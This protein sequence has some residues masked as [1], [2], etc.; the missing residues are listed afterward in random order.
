MKQRPPALGF[1][2]LASSFSLLISGPSARASEP[3]HS[4]HRHATT[5]SDEAMRKMADSYW[6]THKRVGTSATIEG[7]PAATF[8]VANFAF[9]NA[10]NGSTTAEIVAGQSVLWQW[11]VG[12]HTVTSG[13]D[14]TDPNA[15]ALFNQPSDTFNRTFTFTFNTPGTYPFF[16]FFHG[17]INGM[18][19][20]VI[21]T[22]P[23]GVEPLPDNGQAT[24]FAAGPLPNPTRA[25]ISFRFSLR[26]PGPA[27]AEVFDTRGRRIAT[28]LD[29]ELPA[30][31]YAGSWDGR[32][33]TG[34]A[35]AGIYYLRL[36][37]PGFAASRRFA[38]TH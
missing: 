13:T 7:A 38:I 26:T 5:M 19:G 29:R 34:V 4:S 20:Q 1:L 9:S 21:V 18:K 11:V 30:G 36:R 12:S 17:E 3:D 28:V 31:L 16:C 27:R 6:E 15:G 24:G 8:R 14:E 23:A 35:S 37:L 10:A 25:G 32:T 2:A 33:R 22:Q